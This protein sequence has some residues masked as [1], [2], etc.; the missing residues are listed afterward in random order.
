MARGVAFQ[1]V[2]AL[3]VLERQKVADEVKGLDQ[4]RAR[5]LAQIRRALRRLSHLHAGAAQAGA[6]RAG[7]AALGAQARRPETQGARADRS[8]SPPA[9]A[10]RSPPTRRSR[11]RSTAPPAI[12]SAASARCAS[13]SWSGLPISSVR[14]WPG[15]TDAPGTKPPGAIDGCGF[16]VT[17]GMTSLVGCSGEDFASIL[18]SLG[19]RMEKRPKPAEPTALRRRCRR[20]R[21]ATGSAA[22]RLMPA[23]RQS[24][25]RLTAAPDDAA[26]D[27]G[28]ASHVPVDAR[29]ARSQPQRP[30]RGSSVELPG[31]DRHR[32]ARSRTAETTAATG[33]GRSQAR[34][35]RSPTRAG[36]RRRSPAR[37]IAERRRPAGRRV[38]APTHRR[39]AGEAGADDG[40]CGQRRGRGREPEFIEVWRPGRRDEHPR[41]APRTHG[42]A[43]SAAA[44]AG[45]KRRRAAAVA[46]AAADTVPA[47]EAAARPRRR[48][49]SRARG[50]PAPTAAEHRRAA[51]ARRPRC[52]TR[53]ATERADRVRSSAAPTVRARGERPRSAADRPQRG[54]SRPRHAVIVPTATRSAG[55]IHQRA[56]RGQDRRD[57]ASRIRIRRSP[58]SRRSRSSSR[59]TPR[60][61][62]GEVGFPRT[63]V[64]AA[65]R[66][67]AL[68]NLWTASASINGSGTRGW[69]A[70][71]RRRPRS[72]LP[73]TCASTASASTRRAAPCGRATS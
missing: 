71:A 27:R 57:Q 59:R 34:W 41:T 60:S 47:A 5:D 38:Q 19:Y 67:P 69:C 39:R 7:D 49:P 11:R 52:S 10:P 26:V 15:A 58:S 25:G 21:P 63:P 46:A 28:T 24:C 16:T 9:A 33:R 54:G 43:G 4:P 13:T 6:A 18:R 1:L 40:R 73:A 2:E 51:A 45:R 37:T 56:Q 53:A 31:S 70:R 12:A 68:G 23:R 72:P 29:R 8:S 20:K 22:R 42:R 65:A 3:G 62:L 36:R 14:R 17:V 44:S 55:E 32:R 35:R 64:R 30:S 66:S 61:P 48:R 50:W